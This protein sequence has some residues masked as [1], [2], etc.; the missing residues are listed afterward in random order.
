[1]KYSRSTA[2]K[3]SSPNQLIPHTSRNPKVQYSVSNIPL[4]VHIQYFHVMHLHYMILQS[5]HNDMFRHDCHLQ[6]VN[7]KRKTIYS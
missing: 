1:M 2:A 4:I 7:T 5:L 6:G 3:I